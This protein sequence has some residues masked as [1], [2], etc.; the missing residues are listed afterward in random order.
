MDFPAIGHAAVGERSKTA[1][2]QVCQVRLGKLEGTSKL[3]FCVVDEAASPILYQAGN[4][5]SREPAASAVGSELQ[6]SII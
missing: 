5:S 1:L 6:L 4:G 2:I 3:L